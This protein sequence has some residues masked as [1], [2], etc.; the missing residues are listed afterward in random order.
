C[1]QETQLYFL[2][3]PGVMALTQDTYRE[4]LYDLLFQ[5]MNSTN[6]EY[7]YNNQDTESLK[8]YYL[9]H[10]SHVI[11]LGRRIGMFWVP[12]IKNFDL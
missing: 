12:E 6:Y 8:N 10:Q 3:A 1:G 9:N 11:G 2:P 7:N 4:I 5:R